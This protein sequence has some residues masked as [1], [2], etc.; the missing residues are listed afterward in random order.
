M[1][2]HNLKL[3]L[4]YFDISLS[5]LSDKDRLVSSYAIWTPNGKKKTHMT[6]K[7]NQLITHRLMLKN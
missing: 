1:T 6:P 7:R 2:L 3:C 4:E 5:V